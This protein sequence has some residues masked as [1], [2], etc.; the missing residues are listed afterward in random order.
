MLGMLLCRWLHESEP[1]SL[2]PGAVLETMAT[3]EKVERQGCV[4]GTR[5][6]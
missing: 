2:T 1:H 4:T 6:Y 3:Q 5:F